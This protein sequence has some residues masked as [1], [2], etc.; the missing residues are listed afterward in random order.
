MLLSRTRENQ[1]GSTDMTERTYRAGEMVY[2]RGQMGN[3]ASSAYKVI[4]R[5]P[6]ESGAV[7]RYRIKNPSEAFERVAFEEQLSRSP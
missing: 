5:L 1:I 2:Y 3:G 6:T 4:T 7:A